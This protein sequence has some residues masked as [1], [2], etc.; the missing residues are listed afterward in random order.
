M[1][2]IFIWDI[3]WCFDELQDL[4]SKLGVQ[5]ND[6][7]FF[8]WDMVNRWPKSFEVLEFLYNNEN[9][10]AV[11]W[12]HEV[13]LLLHIDGLA[14]KYENEQ[15][16][17]L[18]RHLIENPDLL[19]YIR[20]LPPYIE[21]KDF[22]LVHAGVLTWFEIQ[23]QLEKTLTEIYYHEDLPWY[24]YY[25][26]SSKKIIYGH[27]AENGLQIRLNT[28]WLDSGCAIWGKLSA[29]ILETGDILQ[30]QA[31]RKYLTPKKTW[32]EAERAKN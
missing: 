1:R 4:V 3:H 16:I 15:Y 17:K 9:Y 7:V 21:D 23:G 30:V 19:H 20:N 24:M 13:G 8:V 28:V 11:K 32:Y 29:Y 27:W 14:P 5:K 22:L 25:P 18:R 12:N 26:E 2:H 10:F 6:R 31:N